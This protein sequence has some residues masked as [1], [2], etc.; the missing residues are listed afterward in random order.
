[1]VITRNGLH[2]WQDEKGVIVLDL[3]DFLLQNDIG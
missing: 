1:M 3:F 2:T